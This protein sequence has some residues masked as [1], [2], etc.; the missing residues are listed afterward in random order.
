VGDDERPPM[1]ERNAAYRALFENLP[2]AG[3]PEY[4]AKLEDTTQDLRLPLEVLAMCARERRKAGRRDDFVRLYELI[5][6][7][8]N[9]A[10][11]R[12]A[13]RL[14]PQDAR[15]RAGIVEDIMQECALSLWL[16][17]DGED[18]PFLT[19]GFWIRVSR[20]MS[21][22]A[23]QKRIEE[24]L[25]KRKD[26]DHSTRVLQ[27]NSE[28][29]DRPMGPD[30]DRT[31]GETIPDQQAEEDFSLL[32]FVSDVRD[33]WEQLTPDERFLLQNEITGELTQA[34]I[35]KRLGISD[36]AVRLRLKAL[37]AKVRALLNPPSDGGPAAA[38]D[39]EEGRS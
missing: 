23:T 6:K 24:G 29:L 19:Q 21:N 7:K 3:S 11:R 15:D 36:R 33:V 1:S 16:E 31:R 22:I 28:S 2:P 14:I 38:A 10:L 9:T 30:D 37:R 35:A 12:L 34:Q 13:T 32:E 26:A 25:N 27:S 5:L 8:T 20:M 39:G 18:D 17:L 4:W